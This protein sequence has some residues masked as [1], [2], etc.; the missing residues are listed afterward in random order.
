MFE[1]IKDTIQQK[2]SLEGKSWIFMSCFWKDNNLILSHGVLISD[3]KLEIVIE[4]IYKWIIKKEENNIK[5]IICDII[6]KVDEIIDT[7][8]IIWLDLTVRW[9][10][11]SNLDASKSG[12]LL[13]HTSGVN[14]VSDALQA[15]KT[16]NNL[17]GESI[18][19]RFQS[20]KILISFS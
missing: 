15:L 12:V 1:K 5:Y 16:K 10:S 3:K 9:L 2:I 11:I 4:M 6:T 20:E 8:D 14:S 13:P 7:Q 19:Y 17:E 18:I